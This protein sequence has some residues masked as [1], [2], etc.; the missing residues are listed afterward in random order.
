MTVSTYRKESF[1]E[2]DSD[3]ENEEE[4]EISDKE[5]EFTKEG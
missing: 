2:I 1:D 4:S 5:D 3:D